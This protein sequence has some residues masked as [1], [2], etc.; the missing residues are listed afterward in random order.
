[1]PE[2]IFHNQYKHSVTYLA[3]AQLF[4]VLLT[5]LPHNLI[6][7]N[8]T[9]LIGQTYNKE[10]SLYLACNEKHA[11]LLLNNLKDLNCGHVRKFLRLSISLD[12]MHVFI[13]FKTKLYR[14]IVRIPMDTNCTPLVADLFL[15]C[16]ERDFMLSLSDNKQADVVE[17]FNSISRFLEDVLYIDKPYFKQIVSQ[18]YPTEL[19]LK[20]ANS[21][22]TEAPLWT[23]T[24]Q[25]LMA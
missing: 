15:F 9:E 22:G 8:L 20:K 17:S 11:F 4:P 6:K 13:R 25:L 12:N 3:L 2:C 5:T 18:I 10:C 19:Q 7:D 21:S 23:W 1:M 16:Y 24:C 14:Q